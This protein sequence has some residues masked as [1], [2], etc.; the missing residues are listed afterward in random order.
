MDQ[1]ILIKINELLIDYHNIISQYCDIITIKNYRTTN[2]N[3][4]TICLRYL[5]RNYIFR[6]DINM[7]NDN[8]MYE[9][10]K[11]IKK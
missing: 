8:K 1:K 9:K 2:K 3:I 11:N 6:F 10:C 5:Q 7:I 4:E